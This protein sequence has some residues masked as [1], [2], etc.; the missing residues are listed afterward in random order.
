[1]ERARHVE[2]V[3][4]IMLQSGRGDAGQARRR[5]RADPGADLARKVAYLSR[6]RRTCAQPP[7]RR[8]SRP[9]AHTCDCLNVV[10]AAGGDIADGVVLLERKRR[11]QRA[12]P[13]ARAA[14]GVPPRQLRGV[15]FDAAQQ[16][17]R[18]P[19]DAA[20]ALLEEL[21]PRFRPVGAE[22]LVRIFSAWALLSPNRSHAYWRLLLRVH[23]ERPVLCS[24]V[25]RLDIRDHP[26]DPLR[27]ALPIL[28][29][30]DRFALG[31]DDEPS[32]K[33]RLL[34][35]SAPAARECVLE[36]L[37]DP[38]RL[39][40]DVAHHPPEDRPR[41]RA[42]TAPV[43]SYGRAHRQT[44][45]PRAPPG[46]FDSAARCDRHLLPGASCRSIHGRT[47][48][49]REGLF[50]PA[51]ADGTA[52]SQLAAVAQPAVQPMQKHGSRQ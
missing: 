11:R 33:Q 20:L 7:P 9:R 18:A 14:E 37:A 52:A 43:P 31:F 23:F 42:R 30:A 17:A 40:N 25:V 32:K 28:L 12:Q 8:W 2:T 13:R 35:V 39:A 19:R 36:V 48:G 27:A 47:V 46:R 26:S 38:R 1:M 4:R 16:V 22:E 34:W 6:R 45:S 3:A 50:A 51:R 24:F 49:G 44:T 15:R 41:D 29:A 5:V 10:P 21:G